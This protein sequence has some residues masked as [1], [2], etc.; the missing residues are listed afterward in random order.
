MSVRYSPCLSTLPNRVTVKPVT[1]TA[2][3]FGQDNLRFQL[4]DDQMSENVF[5]WDKGTIGRLFYNFF[6]GLSTWTIYK[7]WKTKVS[8]EYRS[9]TYKVWT[10]YEVFVPSFTDVYA[11]IHLTFPLLDPRSYDRVRPRPQTFVP[12]RGH[13][14]CLKYNTYKESYSSK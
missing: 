4:C 12:W 2:P 6:F 11:S 7:L 13:R 14:V 1:D 8:R 9:L 10:R 5:Q 3:Y